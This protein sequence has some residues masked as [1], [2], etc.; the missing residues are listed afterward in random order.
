MVLHV[1]LKTIDLFD[2]DILHKLL[3]LPIKHNFTQTL[4]IF[5]WYSVS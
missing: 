1:A 3:S 2:M 5:F 4:M